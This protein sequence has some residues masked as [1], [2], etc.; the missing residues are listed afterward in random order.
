[1]KKLIYK[2]FLYSNFALV[3]VTLLSYL[4]TYVSPEDS[5]LLPFFGLIYP[6]LLIVHIG[7]IGLWVWRK[8]Y[9]WIVSLITILI[10]WSQLS[11]FIQIN[12]AKEPEKDEQTFK[13]MSYNVRLFDLYNWSKTKG[14]R[15]KIFDLIENEKP[16]ILCIQEFYSSKKAESSIL[17]LIKQITGLTNYHLATVS[18]QKSKNYIG[19]ITFTRFPV[20]RKGEIRYKKTH[21][22]S[23]WTDIKIGRDTFRVFNNHL[24]SLHFGHDNYNFIDSIAKVDD[25]ERVTGIKKIYWKFLKAYRKRASQAEILSQKVKSSPYPVILSGDFNDIPFSY[26]TNKVKGN[27][28][29]AFTG[30]GAGIC[31]TY[32]SMVSPYRID[33]IFYQSPLKVLDFYV[34]REPLSDHY[35]VISTFALPDKKN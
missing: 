1:L 22:L 32:R 15:D 5:T 34:R 19:L 20:I 18:K 8:R 30:A 29:D 10:G 4:S 13:F 31:Q 11:S 14:T 7:F 6:Y 27:L 33:Y 23:I 35:P 28:K 17:N 2:S 26:T 24:E 9:W 12:F 21:N 25:D 16:D 3:F